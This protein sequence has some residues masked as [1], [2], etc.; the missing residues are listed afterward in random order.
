[1]IA[2]YFAFTT[3]TT[4][5]FGDYHPISTNEMLIC[6]NML[7]FG[8]LLQSY[9]MGC[10]IEILS[11]F[12]SFDEEINEDDKLTRFLSTL[13]RFNSGKPLN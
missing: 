10:F 4:V 1:M 3:L 6:V 2:L 13:N 9:I 12:R 11:D 7:L 8:V 5:G